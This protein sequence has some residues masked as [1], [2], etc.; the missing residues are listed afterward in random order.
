MIARLKKER[1][2]ARE[3][4][5]KADRRAPVAGTAPVAAPLAVTSNGK[6]GLGFFLVSSVSIQDDQY[7]NDANVK[8]MTLFRFP[9][10]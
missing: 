7:K 1:D 2:E 6:R 3:L 8:R 5:L 9:F 10:L 4:L